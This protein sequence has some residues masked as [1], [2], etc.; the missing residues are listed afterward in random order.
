[1]EE[2]LLYLFGA[3][4]SAYALPLARSYWGKG[5]P[6]VSRPEVPG[7]SLALRSI[8][9]QSTTLNLD[10][11]ADFKA[12]FD[13]LANMADEYG[14]VD[15]YAKFV[16]IKNPGGK[17]LK[18]VKRVLSEFFTIKQMAL[19]ARDPR[20]LQW[21]I[22][23]M[24]R[25]IFPEN[26]KVLTWNYDFQI[27][28][29]FKE[30]NDLEDI[31]YKQS[32]YVYSPSLLRYF[33]SLDPNF[34][35]YNELSLIHLNGVAGFTGRESILQQKYIDAGLSEF[36]SETKNHSSAI[37]FAWDTGDYASGLLEHIKNM[38]QDTTI[39]VVVGYSFPFFN[40]S[41]D[42]AILGFLKS[43]SKFKKIYFQDPVLNGEQ[44][45]S[46][47]SIDREIEIVHVK[48]TTNFLVPFE[49]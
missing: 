4:A 19:K 26:V 32:S 33:P 12:R 15:T 16:H 31:S 18:E 9:F 38:V 14:D 35:E 27:Q 3:G 39:L 20:Y 29:A 37:H 1:M 17:E 40:R 23:I 8:N 11:Q 22:S 43:S 34:R 48:N 49:Y 6:G 25:P 47:F 21:L 28:I 45:R 36:L 44:L 24:N 2:R 42:K 7:L 46:Q 5:L 30:F 13:N 10:Q 41:V